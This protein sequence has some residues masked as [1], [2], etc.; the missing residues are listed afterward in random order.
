MKKLLFFILAI[1]LHCTAI[2]AGDF[3]TLEE[4]MTGK[5]FK[6]TGL[7]KLTDEELSALN[8]WVRRHSVA[9]LETA[10]RPAAASTASTVPVDDIRGF[11]N[12]PKDA[13]SDKD[14]ESSIVGTFT[15]WRGIGTQ[16]KLANGMI[17]EQIEAENFH[18]KATENAE[19]VISKTILGGWRLSV[20]GYG[21]SV[22][23]KRI[24]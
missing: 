17:W 2:A 9:T 13:S 8:D 3:S 18:V 5:E 19:I 6:E 14:I 10:T 24:K 11:E 15:G 23:V 16:F 21:S 4:K 1:S 12:Q 22:R 7:E 20:V